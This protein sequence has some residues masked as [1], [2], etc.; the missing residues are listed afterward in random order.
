LDSSGNPHISYSDEGFD[1]N[2][3][4]KYAALVSPQTSTPTSTPTPTPLADFGITASAGP[5]GTISPEGEGL[6]AYPGG[7]YTFII[8][9][10]FGYRIL[11]VTVDG[12]SQGNISTYTLTNIQSNH[13]ISATFAPTQ[14]PTIVV[15]VGVVVA[16]VVLVGVWFGVSRARKRSKP[17]FAKDSTSS[18]PLPPA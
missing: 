8:T 14:T 9:P 12:V 3:G 2:A 11:D 15:A 18:Y 1:I 16:V 6:F 4:L 5:G 10:D 7:S 13:E 17:S